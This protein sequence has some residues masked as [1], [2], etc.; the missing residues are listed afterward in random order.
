MTK[1]KKKK[2]FYSFPEETTNFSLFFI[3]SIWLQLPTQTDVLL[4]LFLPHLEGGE[5]KSPGKR[6]YV[7]RVTSQTDQFQAHVLK[8]TSKQVLKDG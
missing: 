6:I 4:L 8:N 2:I 7:S 3:A 5:T 1:K